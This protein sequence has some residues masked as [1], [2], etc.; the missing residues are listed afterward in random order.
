PG[1]P[2]P[3]T[4]PPLGWRAVHT[5]PVR[6]GGRVTAVVSLA[7][8]VADTFADHHLDVARS[9]SAI[10]AGH[11]QI[12]RSVGAAE[13]LGAQLRASLHRRIIIEQAKGMLAAQLDASIEQAVTMSHHHARSQDRRLEDLATQIVTGD[14]RLAG[15]PD[16][17]K[18]TPSSSL[19]HGRRHAETTVSGRAT[20]PP[21][22]TIIDTGPPGQVELVG[23]A[24]LATLDQF[25]QACDVL[26]A[27]TGDVIIDLSRLDFLDAGSV[28]LLVRTARRL[29]P[30]RRLLLRGATGCVARIL[31]VLQIE[32][33]E[34]LHVLSAGEP[35]P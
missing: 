2:L 32:Q 14:V 34:Q 29:R 5:L 20:R 21:Q 8:T 11:V 16:P 26:A 30:P 4:A 7:S 25:R 23:E 1:W 6:S 10:G 15:E 13:R 12:V 33:V 24:D 27:Q 3:P 18:A 22:L 19:T 28:G 31:A 9:L 35:A 17:T